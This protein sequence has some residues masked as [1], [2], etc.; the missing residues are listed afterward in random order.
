MKTHRFDDTDVAAMRTALT[1]HS[2]GDDDRLHLDF[3]LGKAFE[4]R[5][6]YAASFRH[7]DAGNAVRR[8]QII[9]DEAANQ[10]HRQQCEA[11]FTADFFAA[12]E[13][14]GCAARDPIFVVGLP[15]SGSTLIEQILSSHSQ[16]EGTMELPDIAAIARGL[17]DRTVPKATRWY[18]DAL[19]AAGPDELRALGEEYLARTRIQRRTDRPRFV[20]KMPNNFAYTALIH[21]AL[22]N[23]TIID[24]RRHPVATC[25]SAWKQHF[26]RGQ[27]YT[28]DLGELGRFYL[29]YVGLMA[30]FDRVLPGRVL[31]VDHEALVTDT[32][33]QV[34]RILDHCGLDFEPGCLAFHENKRA[35]RT[36]SSEQVRQPITS[37]GLDQWKHFDPWLGDLKATLAAVL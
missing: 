30:H 26:A 23:A 15:R 10:A 25:F 36:A 3:A 19:A 33:A 29:D 31:R 21:L 12:R 7:Y 35:V 9:W 28:Y 24:A 34:R 16:V 20:D 1:D 2:L 14:Q 22:P 13:D 17:A 11:L 8:G 18:L 4:D 37:A 5:A 27:T 32:E 6:D